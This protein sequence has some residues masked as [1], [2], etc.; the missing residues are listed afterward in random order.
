[1]TEP[2]DS[3]NWDEFGSVDR[4]I[5]AGVVVFAVLALAETRFQAIFK[6][7][8]WTIII[9]GVLTKL[10]WPSMRDTVSRVVVA[11]IYIVH[12]IVMNLLYRY[13]PSDGYI[14]I[15]IAIV[16]EVIIFSVPC[17]WIVFRARQS[18]SD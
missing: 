5:L 16:V 6:M 4:C 8:V 15:G 14:A 3:E 18:R 12:F 11:L 13:L 7:A 1:M 10:V 17:G 2:D 9:L